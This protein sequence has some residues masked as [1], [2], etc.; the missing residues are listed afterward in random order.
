MFTYKHY[1][2]FEQYKRMNK[3]M[4]LLV[5]YKIQNFTAKLRK[6]YKVKYSIINLIQ[7]VFNANYNCQFKQL[8]K[9]L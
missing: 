2:R 7:I 5:L 6:K 8:R 1:L 4:N 9:H 3:F